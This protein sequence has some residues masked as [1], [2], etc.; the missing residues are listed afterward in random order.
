[1]MFPGNGPGGI[2]H[3]RVF[4]GPGGIIAIVLFVLFVVVLIG[5]IIF[6]FNRMGMHRRMWHSDMNH[7]PLD[8]AKERYAKG[9]ITADELDKIK[10]NLS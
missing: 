2:Q 10:K 1:M 3:V 8:I 4:I 9:E 5:L 7:E 6:A